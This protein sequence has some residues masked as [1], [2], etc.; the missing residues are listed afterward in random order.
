MHTSSAAV[1]TFLNFA[2]LVA[3][4][5]VIVEEEC[6]L[7]WAL[8]TGA[9]GVAGSIAASELAKRE[10]EPSGQ[11]FEAVPFQAAEQ[12]REPANA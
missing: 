2:R 12:A 7:G 4:I 6:G 10:S 9:A 11:E 1:A 5:L 8:A 3:A